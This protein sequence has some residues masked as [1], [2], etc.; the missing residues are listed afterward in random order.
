MRWNPFRRELDG[1]L[2]ATP[3]AA[4]RYV[5]LDTELT[6]LDSRSNRLLS[7]GAFAMQGGS[8]ELAGQFYRLANPGVEVPAPGV[9]IHGLRPQD[10]A[11]GD[12]ARKVIEDLAR[13][14]AGAVIVGHFVS[15]DLGILRKEAPGVLPNPA[16]CT[17]RVHSWMLRGGPLTEEVTRKLE[18]L[19][20]ESVAR[21]YAVEPR[22][23]HHALGD[24]WV[25]AQVWQRMIPALARRK[26]VTVGDL[27]RAGAMRR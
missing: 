15:I 20:L 21:Q 16:I 17:A 24:A 11:E 23:A 7:V 14:A 8:I 3:L 4:A 27:R 18:L 22:D 25:T 19:D 12:P 1:E 10:V 26:V 9:L 13:F 5:V 6:S 2:S